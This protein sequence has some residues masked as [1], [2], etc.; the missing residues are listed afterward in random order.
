MVQ[1]MNASRE[2]IGI[3]T[4]EPL[5]NEK[6]MHIGRV[7]DLPD[8]LTIYHVNEVIFCAKDIPADQII[9]WMNRLQDRQLEFKIAP[10]DSLSLIGS[11]DIFTSEDLY[12]IPLQS[13]YQ[14]K[15]RRQKRA[16]DAVSALLLLLFLWLDIWFV[17]QKCGLVRNIFAVLQ[18]RKSWVGL[19]T[20]ATEPNAVLVPG[21]L[22]PSDAYPDNAFSE[23]MNHRLE[24]IYAR[25]YQ[26]RNDLTIM[27]KGF[28][29]LGE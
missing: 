19:E 27:A 8:L 22:H 24:E 1:S 25:N 20:D 4:T 2:F 6:S 3:I 23:E 14:Q 15:S 10:E 13:V 28:V 16:F 26:V 7:E 5:D 9:S 17:K 11:N 18:G 21:V 29:R 12:T